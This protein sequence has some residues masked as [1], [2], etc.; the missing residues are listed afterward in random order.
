[1]DSLFVSFIHHPEKKRAAAII[2]RRMKNEKVL[3]TTQVARRNI[4]HTQVSL[5]RGQ[6]RGGKQKTFFLFS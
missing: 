3:H 1:M 2:Y 6:V 4:L 5:V